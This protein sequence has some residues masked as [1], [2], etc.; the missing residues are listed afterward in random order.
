MQNSVS[1]PDGAGGFRALAVQ[2]QQIWVGPV[3]V[4]V[5]SAREGELP[6]GG[7]GVRAVLQLSTADKT[8][9]RTVV[10]GETI[11]FP[12][13][14]SLVVAG[15]VGPG[16]PAPRSDDPEAD[17]VDRGVVGL[18]FHPDTVPADELGV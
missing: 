12:G 9:V 7:T 8:S 2:G 5:M 13:L 11:G 10:A 1:A 16:E 18:E 4:G 15:I 3:H 14:G 17:R 6:D